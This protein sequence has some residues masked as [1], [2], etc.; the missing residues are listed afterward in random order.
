VRAFTPYNAS[1]ETVFEFRCK[2]T[3]SVDFFWGAYPCFV[4]FWKR[5]TLIRSFRNILLAGKNLAYVQN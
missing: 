3:F 5:S 4:Y 1:L 2:V